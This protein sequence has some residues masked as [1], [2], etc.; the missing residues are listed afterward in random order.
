MRPF[1]V[2]ATFRNSA[3]NQSRAAP[4]PLVG[5]FCSDSVLRVPKDTSRRIDLSMFR[6]SI[7]RITVRMSALSAR[8]TRR[9]LLRV[10]A[11]MNDA[12]ERMIDDASDRQ[13]AGC[14]AS[15]MVSRMFE[16]S[17]WLPD[18]KV[19]DRSD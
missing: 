13:K 1:E 17:S 8:D 18:R 14:F 5:L 3:Y 2:S 19:H 16:C 4:I 12:L 11:G 6:A 15:F 7:S 9:E 10:W